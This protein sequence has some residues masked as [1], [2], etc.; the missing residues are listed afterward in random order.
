MYDAV[1]KFPDTASAI[2]C[3]MNVD[4][5]LEAIAP[6]GSRDLFEISVRPTAHF[7]QSSA[8]MERYHERLGEKNWIEIGPK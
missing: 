1:K 4:G 5:E 3:K 8:R 2:I 7:K 6:Y